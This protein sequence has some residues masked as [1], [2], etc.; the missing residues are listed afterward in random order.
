MLLSLIKLVLH[1]SS[2]SSCIAHRTQLMLLFQ[3]VSKALADGAL[4]L[5]DNDRLLLSSYS[6]PLA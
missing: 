4:Q 6:P 3:Q 2:N 1:L 5:Q